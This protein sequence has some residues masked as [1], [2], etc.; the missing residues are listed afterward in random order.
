MRSE[1]GAPKTTKTNGRAAAMQPDVPADVPAALPL[2]L[3]AAP[4]PHG[5]AADD[6][7]VLHEFGR[8]RICRC[9]RCGLVRLNPRL[10]AAQLADFYACA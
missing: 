7:T 4:C 1:T 5:C 10:A 8:F 6:D 9:G 3:E 2:E